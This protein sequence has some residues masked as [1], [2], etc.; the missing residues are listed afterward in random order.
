[1]CTR[2]SFAALVAILWVLAACG[3]T[4]DA[5]PG[6]G[7]RDEGGLAGRLVVTGSSTLAPLVLEI[8]QRFEREHP[9]V[10]VDVQ[11]GGSGRGI[12]DVRSGNADIGMASRPLAEEEGDLLAF[13]LARD[14]VSLIVHRENPV[15]DLTEAQVVAIF[16]G[17]ITNWQEVGGENRAISVVNKAA[18]R[19]TLEVFLSYLGLDPRRVRSSVVVGDN[20]QGIKTVAGNR[21]A[22]GY[23]SIGTAEADAALGVPVKLLGLGGVAANSANVAA[24]TFPMARPLNLVTRETPTGLSEAFLDFARSDRVH[25]LIQAHFFVPIGS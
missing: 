24:G 23:V 14:G 6:V 20:E 1:M 12:A 2:S 25:D 22:I 16:S 4:S 13:S 18:G 9:G 21:N 19:A 3:D 17:E 8:G 11:T 15:R 7:G 10:R 5:G